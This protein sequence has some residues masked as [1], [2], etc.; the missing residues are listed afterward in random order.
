MIE[1]K[2]VDPATAPKPWLERPATIRMLWVVSGVILAGLVLADLA[3]EH[4]SHFGVDGTMGFGA[5]YGFAACVVLVLAAKALGL[6][7]KKPDSYYDR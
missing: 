4:H 3:I 6:L 5:W 1:P 7:L 2:R